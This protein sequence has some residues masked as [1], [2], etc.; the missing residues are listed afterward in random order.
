[1]PNSITIP[2]GSNQ[3]SFTVNATAANSDATVQLSATLNGVSTTFSLNVLAVTVTVSPASVTLSMLEHQQFTATVSNTSNTT[4]SWSLNPNVGTIS[5]SGLY[6]APLLILS[7]QTVTV[8]ATSAADPTKTA[9]AQVTL[10][11]LLGL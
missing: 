10:V 7:R 6:S 9:T 11:P 5:S 8:I 1:M 3:G 2:A 4:V